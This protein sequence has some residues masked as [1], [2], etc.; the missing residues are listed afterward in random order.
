MKNL[1]FIAL[2]TIFCAFSANAQVAKMTSVYTNLKT[3]CQPE[4]KVVADEVPFI[5]KAVGGFRVRIIP[6]GAWAETIEI[7]DKNKET[8]ASLGTHGYG[9]SIVGKRMLEWRMANGKPF[10]VIFRINKYSSEEALESGDNPYLDKYKTGEALIIRGL[11]GYSQIDFEVDGKEKN[12][13][14]KAQKLADENF[15]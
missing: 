15:Q 5:C 13:N 2:L 12:A 3:D 14:V 7:V 4:V 11:T 6:A 9:Y 8:V 1:I 10:A